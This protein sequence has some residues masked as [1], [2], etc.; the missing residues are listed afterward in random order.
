[1]AN[2][3]GAGSGNSI[4]RYMSVDGFMAMVDAVKAIRRDESR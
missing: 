4:P 3:Y 2:G 1:M